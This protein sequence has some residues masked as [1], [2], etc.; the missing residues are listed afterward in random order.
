MDGRRIAG[1]KLSAD[2]TNEFLELFRRW[3]AAIRNR[4]EVMREA[5]A[6]K[7]H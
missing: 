4:H 6:A 3:N 7:D 5:G 1:L 2:E